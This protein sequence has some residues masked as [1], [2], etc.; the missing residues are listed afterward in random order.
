MKQFIRIKKLKKLSDKTSRSVHV[1]NQI[2]K[3]NT[4]YRNQIDFMILFHDIAKFMLAMM[5]NEIN[6]SLIEILSKIGHFL[7]ADRVYIVKHDLKKNKYTIAYEWSNDFTY[8]KMVDNENIMTSIVL[9]WIETHFKKHGICTINIDELK[10]E[11]KIYDTLKSLGIKSQLAI[12]MFQGSVVYGFLGFD[13]LYNHHVY[14]DSDHAILEQLSSFLLMVLQHME[15]SYQNK[16][17]MNILLSITNEQRELICRLDDKGEIIFVNQKFSQ[18]FGKK[19]PQLL[20]GVSIYDIAPLDTHW[21]LEE[22]ITSQKQFDENNRYVYQI[23]DSEDQLKWIEWEA[24][25][26]KIENQRQEYQLVGRDFS[27]TKKMEAA[28]VKEK[29]KLASIIDAAKVGT[30]EWSISTGNIKVNDEFAKMLGYFPD[31]FKYMTATQYLEMVHPDYIDEIK[32]IIDK[33]LQAKIN[34]FRIEFKMRERSNKFRWI[35][36]QGSISNRYNDGLPMTIYGIHIDIQNSKE[37]EEEISILRTSLENSQ[38]ITIITDSNGIII[39]VNPVFTKL[40]GYTLN[41]VV[42]LNPDF[43]QSDYYE[44]EYIEDMWKTVKSGKN[45]HGEFHNKKKDGTYFWSLATITPIINKKGKITHYV[46]SQFDITDK[47][48]NEEKLRLY[49]EQLRKDVS[50]KLMEIAES[51]RASVIALAR[52]TES[53]D[54]T[55]GQHVDRVQYLCRTLAESLMDEEYYNKDVNQEF[56]DDIFYASILHDIGKVGISDSVLLKPGKFTEEEFEIMKSHVVLGANMLQDI[57]DMYPNNRII[58][59][60]IEIAKFHHEKWNGKGY[61]NGLSYEAIPLSARIMAIVDAYDAIRS[62]R[63]YK[64]PLCHEEAVNLIKKDSGEHFD[65]H[66]VKVFLKIEHKFKDIFDSKSSEETFENM[67]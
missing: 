47:I 18:L 49:N 2:N 28:L 1:K 67:L 9:Y 43:L 37:N 25:P 59:M 10:N 14:H 58:E 24:Y 36:G 57:A 60:G 48:I 19:S 21:M 38:T 64:Q 34:E 7:E 23:L 51:H 12:P 61:P 62:K 66:L 65:P 22:L 35:L 55:T 11:S 53:R 26:I 56:V 32:D 42:G 50:N 13:F 44:K 46:S 4:H 41:E 17:I 39:Y 5:P 30:F 27:S 63:P 6:L 29:I 40:T 8:S 54:S 3:V 15:L 20:F 52:I 45:W 31:E 33:I 16:E